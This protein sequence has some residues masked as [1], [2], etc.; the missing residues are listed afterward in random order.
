[1][2]KYLIVFFVIVIL[3]ELYDY[4][5]ENSFKN[6]LSVTDKMEIINNIINKAVAATNQTFVNELK[7]TGVF[8]QEQQVVAYNK[9]KDII[10]ELLTDDLKETLSKVTTSIDSYLNIAIEEAV[11]SN[12]IKL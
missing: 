6:K 1:M 12:K 10:M 7:N 5:K 4:F 3:I 9:T 2:N 8:D 11:E